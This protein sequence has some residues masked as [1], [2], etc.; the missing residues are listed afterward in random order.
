[1]AD[2]CDGHFGI[3]NCCRRPSRAG[4]H[5]CTRKIG[6]GDTGAD[7][8]TK[9]PRGVVVVVRL[10]RRLIMMGG[11]RDHLAMMMRI[12]FA[13][14]RWRHGERKWQAG[15]KNQHG[16]SQQKAI[17]ETFHGAIGSSVQ[18]DRQEGE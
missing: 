8:A 2:K 18:T 15:C 12:A 5:R 1:M 7:A 4:N 10:L 11:A 9:T 17:T 14:Q 16:Y 13:R 6:D 3:N